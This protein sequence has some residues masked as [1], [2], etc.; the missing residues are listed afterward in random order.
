MRESSAATL[1]S[2]LSAAT[3]AA[4]TGATAEIVAHPANTAAQAAAANSF[5]TRIAKLF[6]PPCDNVLNGEVSHAP[7]TFASG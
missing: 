3:G 4:A 5:E 6:A 7:S 2:S 1:A